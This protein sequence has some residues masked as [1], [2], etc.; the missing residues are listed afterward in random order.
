MTKV[1]VTND[2]TT[3]YLTPKEYLRNKR[4]NK[5]LLETEFEAV[6]GDICARI[7]S[8]NGTIV[9]GLFKDKL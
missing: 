6:V 5:D 3:G 1:S 7:S 4:E 8:M 9:G 2:V